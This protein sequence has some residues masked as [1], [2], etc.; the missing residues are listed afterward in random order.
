MSCRMQ[1]KSESRSKQKERAAAQRLPAK[2]PGQTARRWTR[3]PRGTYHPTAQEQTQQAQTPAHHTGISSQKERNGRTLLLQCAFFIF[4]F[5]ECFLMQSVP[6]SE[7]VW[8]DGSPLPALTIL[9]NSELW[10]GAGTAKFKHIRMNVCYED[11]CEN[12]CVGTLLMQCK[13]P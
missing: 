9:L 7:H 6:C 10:G 4:Y 13:S 12:G 11:V 8:H 2:S 5:T 3:T 1:L